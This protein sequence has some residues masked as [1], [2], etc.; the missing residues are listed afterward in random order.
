MNKKITIPSKP[1]VNK[2]TNN[3]D[4]WIKERTTYE[5]KKEPNNKRLTIDL[6]FDLHNKIK[7]YCSS[8]GTQMS[9]EIRK[10][11]FDKFGNE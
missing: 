4:L 11:L 6:P 8:N 9:S 5:Q 7:T 2:N 1:D 3:A 10:L